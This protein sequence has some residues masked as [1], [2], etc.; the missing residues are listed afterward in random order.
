VTDLTVSTRPT[1]T[2]EIKG[3]HA[4]GRRSLQGKFN[5]GRIRV[6]RPRV[7]NVGWYD[8]EWGH[9]SASSIWRWRGG[10]ERISRMTALILCRF[11]AA[12]DSAACQPGSYQYNALHVGSIY[13]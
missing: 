2:D 11:A 13:D 1:T 12:A 10:N 8:D 3:G 9:S 6:L 7:N 5:A 4:R